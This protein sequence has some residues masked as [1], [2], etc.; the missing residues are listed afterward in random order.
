MKTYR[1]AEPNTQLNINREAKTIS[2][3]LQLEKIMGSYA[4]RPGFISLNDHKKIFK[5]NTKCRLIN[6]AKSEIGIVSKTFFEKI[7]N[8]LNN[9]LCYNQWLSTSTAI[10]R[11]RAIKNK[12]NPVN[13]LN[14][15]LQNFTHQYR[16]NYLKNLLIL[17][18]A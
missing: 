5:N 6:P 11:F 2:K 16:Q 14:L 9:H 18:E 13:S 12:K 3:T 7:N 1:K 10:E 15:T 8:K 4:E 17:Q